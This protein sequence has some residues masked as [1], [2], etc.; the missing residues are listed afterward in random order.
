MFNQFLGSLKT[1]GKKN[2]IKGLKLLIILSSI[3]VFEL[4]NFSLIIPIFTMIFNKEAFLDFEI[5]QYIKNFLGDGPKSLLFF[6][7]LFL[8]IVIIKTILLLFFEYKTQKLIREIYIDTSLKAY[9][10]FLYSP[11]HEISS[12]EHA[13]IMRNI[14]SDTGIFCNEGVMKFIGLIKNTFLMS[15]IVLFLFTVNFKITLILLF[16]FIIFTFLFVLIVKKKLIE[17]S[18][19]NAFYD[20]F[21]LK[22]VSESILNLRDIKLNLN[23]DYFLGLYK[24]NEQKVT[25]V[26]IIDKIFRLIPRYTLEIVMVTLAVFAMFLLISKGYYMPDLIPVLGVYGFA[27]MR[28]IPIFIVYNRDIQSIRVSKFQIDEV[29]KNNNKFNQTHDLSKN[30]INK[31]DEKKLLKLQNEL[32]IRVKELSFSYDKTQNIFENLSLKLTTNYTYYLEGTNGSGKSTFVDLISGMLHPNLGSIEVNGLNI[33]DISNIWLKNIGYVSQTN[34]LTNNTIKENIIFGRDNISEKNINEI[35]KLV[36]LDVLIN[37]LPNG[38]NTN[39]G[40]LGS[41]FS[42][43]QKQRISI[44]RSLVCNPK[45]IIFD[46]ATNALDINTEKNFLG[47]IDKI[48]KN[49]IIIFIAH[50]EIIKNFCDI[51]LIIKDKKIEIIN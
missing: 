24:D 17:L 36:G 16:I 41:S 25:K 23:S 15:F 46:E 50:S 35:V 14:L 3:V 31:N 51:K 29:I 18:E 37:S 42:G 5:Y 26:F 19:L 27:A 44:A 1:I 40:N 13:Y 43:G 10:Y 22:N 7:I 38:I 6:G 33:K 2:Q 49:K 39:V 9:S 32:E 48:K 21:R 20:K 8:F 4:L 30:N 47:I 28:L 34:F 45:V 11:W 12:K